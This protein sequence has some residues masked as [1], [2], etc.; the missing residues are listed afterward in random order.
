METRTLL[1]DFQSHNQS[2]S[3]YRVDASMVVKAK[4][5]R[6][7]DFGLYSDSSFTTP[8]E[9]GD[10]GLSFHPLAGV[11]SLIKKVS[12]FNLNGV[13]IDNLT[14]CMN[15]MAMRLT[16]ME[17][18]MQLGINTPTN[19]ALKLWPPPNDENFIPNE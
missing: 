15:N 9:S 8:F 12:I 19:G 14:N 16:H 1:R 7:L 2:R 4:K 17:N 11:Y 5:I 10:K 13:E 6:L 3:V 18:A